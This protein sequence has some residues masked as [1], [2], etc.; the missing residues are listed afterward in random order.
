[1]AKLS[2]LNL[3]LSH[4]L[5]SNN[6]STFL[7]RV[8]SAKRAGY[9][10][11]TDESF[12][13]V[14]TQNF[15]K[16]T[17]KINQWLEDNGLS[18]NALKLKLLSLLEA[19]ETKFFQHEGI[20]SDQ[21]EVDAIETQRRTLDMAMKLKGLYAPT[22]FEHALVDVSMDFGNDGEEESQD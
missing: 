14:G 8:E 11:S 22:K 21:R 10:C 4:F 12:R 5:N 7:N 19:K 13:S 3:W 1:M 17:D 15:T 20:V 2:K 9:N 18:E 6:S 16:C